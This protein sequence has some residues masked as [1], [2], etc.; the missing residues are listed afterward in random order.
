MFSGEGDRSE[1]AFS[2][3]GILNLLM[4]GL[5]NQ[6]V[7]SVLDNCVVGLALGTVW[8]A[9]LWLDRGVATESW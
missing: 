7:A 2:S 9:E 1:A 6:A 5:E 8:A 4:S 3:P